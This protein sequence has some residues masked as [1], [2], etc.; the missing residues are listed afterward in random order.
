MYA[1]TLNGKTYPVIYQKGSFV[2]LLVIRD[3]DKREVAHFKWH[4]YTHKIEGV[5]VSPRFRRNGI[6]TA[7]FMMAREMYP[8]I[9]HSAMR[10]N[11]GEAWALS[12]GEP[13]PQRSEDV[14]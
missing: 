11:D 9:H 1:L 5:W 14:K 12:L 3:K 6:A 10:T 4:E 7:L 13:L 8:D 2:E